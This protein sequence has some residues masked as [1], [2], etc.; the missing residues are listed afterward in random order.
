MIEY[1]KYKEYKDVVF[2]HVSQLHACINDM[3]GCK[4]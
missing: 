1:K 3:G 2:T 4:A